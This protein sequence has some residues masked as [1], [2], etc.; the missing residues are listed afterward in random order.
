MS[1]GG[2]WLHPA[3]FLRDGGGKARHVHAAQDAG[4][5]PGAR[6]LSICGN[7]SLVSYYVSVRTAH[8]GLFWIPRLRVLLRQWT[9]RTYCCALLDTVATLVNVLRSGVRLK[10]AKHG[11]RL[12]SGVGF[13]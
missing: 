8:R 9:R 1:G 11:A 12:S 7:V 2:R 6:K 10:S 13:I 4:N 5:G 3:V